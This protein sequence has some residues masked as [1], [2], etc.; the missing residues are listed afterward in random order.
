MLFRRTIYMVRRLQSMSKEGPLR[1][2]NSRPV[3]FGYLEGM[4]SPEATIIRLDQV[5]ILYHIICIVT[6]ISSDPSVQ[7]G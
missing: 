3:T 1:E 5:A 2:L 4:G 7:T 6:Y